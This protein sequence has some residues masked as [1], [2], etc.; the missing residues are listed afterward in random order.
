MGGQNTIDK[1]GVGKE[2][3]ILVGDRG[4]PNLAKPE[5]TQNIAQKGGKETNR[6]Q[7]RT[8]SGKEPSM[9]Q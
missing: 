9:S 6:T 5:I 2:K 4:G 8:H 7:N 3:R 1:E